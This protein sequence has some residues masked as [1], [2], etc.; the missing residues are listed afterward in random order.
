MLQEITPRSGRPTR[1]FTPA[2]IQKIKDWVAQGM[3]REDIAKS[4]EVTVGSLSSHML[5]LGDQFAKT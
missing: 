5:T 3:G 1:K 2:N 4:L